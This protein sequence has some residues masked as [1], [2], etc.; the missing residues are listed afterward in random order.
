MKPTI[1]IGVCVKNGEAFIEPTIKSIMEQHY[2]YNCMEV[3]YVD[4]SEDNTLAIIKKYLKTSNIK[5]TIIKGYGRGIGSA[6][7]IIVN[8]S[9]GKYIIWVDSDNVIPNNYVEKQVEFMENNDDVGIAA[10]LIW[11]PHKTNLI[12]TLEILPMIAYHYYKTKWNKNDLDKLPGTAG[13]IC[14]VNVLRDVGGFDETI[15]GAGEDIDIATRIHAAGWLICRTNNMYFESH[16]NMSSLK[17]LWKKYIWYGSGAFY[18]LKKNNYKLSIIRMNPFAGFVAGL[19]IASRAYHI[20]NRKIVFL[21]PLHFT[22][23][24]F[25]WLYGYTIAKSSFNPLR[26]H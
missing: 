9:K 22:F 1:T 26:P 11:F 5:S 24:M 19:I 2:P 16:G 4:D 21:C 14:R 15:F 18:H 17:D 23:K 3:I 10:G 8:R 13:T 25:S 7:N 12:L 6:R 20:L